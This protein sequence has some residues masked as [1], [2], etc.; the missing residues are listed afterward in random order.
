MFNVGGGITFI[1]LALLGVGLIVRIILNT[2][3]RDEPRSVP[4]KRMS[5]FSDFEE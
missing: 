3:R 5:R 1:L 2:I 4:F